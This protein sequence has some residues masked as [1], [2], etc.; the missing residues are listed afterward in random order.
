M[1]QIFAI[2]SVKIKLEIFF[3]LEFQN[4]LDGLIFRAQL[5]TYFFDGRSPSRVK[6]Y[7]E[8]FHLAGALMGHFLEGIAPLRHWYINSN[9]KSNKYKSS[10]LS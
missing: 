4:I 10:L 7:T 8:F 9:E 6:T 1:I 3:K 5:F 2:V